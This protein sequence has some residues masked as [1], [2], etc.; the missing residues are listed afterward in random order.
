[1]TAADVVVVNPEGVVVEGRWLPTSELPMHLGV[2]Q[3]RAD[4]LAVVH[5]HSPF[6]TTFACCG[7]PIEAVHYEIALVASGQAIKVAPYATYGTPEL[8]QLAVET[9]AA[10][11]AVLLQNHGVLAVGPTLAKAYAVA[12][13][14]EY[15]AELYLRCLQLGSPLVVPEAEMA[16]VRAKMATYGQPSERVPE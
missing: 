2:Y 11:S 8:A 15:L 13:K 4:A 9:M 14:A 3:H 16:R 1:M 12:Q 5:T 7:R 10:D 6:A